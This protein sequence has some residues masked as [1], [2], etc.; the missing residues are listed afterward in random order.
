MFETPVVFTIFNRPAL[1]ARVLDVLRLVQ[2]AN[3]YVIAD[4]PRATH[5]ADAERCAAA[6]ALM[7]RGRGFLRARRTQP[8]DAG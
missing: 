5:P 3:L 1:T 2:P 8:R 4:G 6:R 7:H